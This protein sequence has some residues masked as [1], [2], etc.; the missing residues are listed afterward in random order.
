VLLVLGLRRKRVISLSFLTWLYRMLLLRTHRD[1]SLPLSTAFILNSADLCTYKVGY[2]LQLR[3][4]I[5]VMFGGHFIAVR[6]AECN[7][8]CERLLMLN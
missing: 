6:G 4:N 5:S 3:T 8:A 7:G 2:N 1:R